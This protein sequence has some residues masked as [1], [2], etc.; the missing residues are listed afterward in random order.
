MNGRR[1]AAAMC[2]NAAAILCHYRTAA[3]HTVKRLN[4][5]TVAVSLQSDRRGLFAVTPAAA[6]NGSLDGQ[7]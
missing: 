3:C 5:T 6:R 2:G 4:D 1:G 7:P